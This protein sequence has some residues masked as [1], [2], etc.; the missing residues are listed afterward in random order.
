[1]GLVTLGFGA[2]PDAAEAAAG[3]VVCK[4]EEKKGGKK[5]KKVDKFLTQVFSVYQN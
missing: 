4:E 5:R 2:E 1:L 3:M